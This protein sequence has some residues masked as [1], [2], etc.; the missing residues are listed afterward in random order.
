MA[1]QKMNDDAEEIQTLKNDITRAIN[2]KALAE[3][4]A[5][6]SINEYDTVVSERERLEV[7]VRKQINLVRAYEIKT[8][9][10]KRGME[11]LTS[12]YQETV[13]ESTLITARENDLMDSLRIAEADLEGG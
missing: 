9:D 6:K 8:Q 1:K 13:R 4:E 12:R 10:L 2:A 11:E 7:E 5:H 3:N